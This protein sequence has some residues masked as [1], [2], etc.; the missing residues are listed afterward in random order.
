MNVWVRDKRTPFVQT[1]RPFE[2]WRWQI[3]SLRNVGE[4]GKIFLSLEVVIPNEDSLPFLVGSVA[5]I[6]YSVV[7]HDMIT[8]IMPFLPA[9]GK[10]EDLPSVIFSSIGEGF[11]RYL[12]FTYARY[13]SET[14]GFIRVAT[15]KELTKAGKRAL[16]PSDIHLFHPKQYERGDLPFIPFDE[17]LPLSWVLG[18]DLLTATE[19]WGPA[20]IIVMGYSNRNEPLVGFSSSAGLSAAPSPEEA[21]IHGFQEFVERDANNIHWVTNIP[22]YSIPLTKEE[23]EKLTKT[24][25]PELPGMRIDVFLWTEYAPE[26]SVVTV[27]VIREDMKSYSY[28]PGIG[29]SFDFATALKKALS[30][31]AQG[32][33]FIPYMHRIKEFYGKHSTYYYVEEDEDPSRIDNLFKTIVYYGYEKNLKRIYKEFF[34]LAPRLSLEEVEKQGFQIYPRKLSRTAQ[35]ELLKQISEKHGWHPAIFDLTPPEIRNSGALIRVLIPEL[36]P[37]Y[38]IS[39][40]VFGHPRYRHAPSILRGEERL[41]DLE[42]LRF[43]PLPYP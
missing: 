38:T 36:T 33:L 26:I 39:L 34:D 15:Y 8:G 32:Q 22:P 20:Q 42:D 6:D 41:L 17:D 31:S 3:E 43:D 11:E 14:P 9:G 10:G 18:V 2:R 30:E 13:I 19:V 24:P 25:L 21:I 27:H 7:L 35:I 16:G 40:P 29:V 4:N 23:I 1:W 12:C 37:Y 28:W 5:H